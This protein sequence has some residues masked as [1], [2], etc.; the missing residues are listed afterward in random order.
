[1]PAARVIRPTPTCLRTVEWSPESGNLTP[2][3]K[4]KRHAVLEHRDNEIEAMYVAPAR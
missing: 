1:M 3:L 2:T 4:M